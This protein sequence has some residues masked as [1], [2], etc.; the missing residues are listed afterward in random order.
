M[1]A[2]EIP[3]PAP[4]VV[5]RNDPVLIAGEDEGEVKINE[6]FI[7]SAMVAKLFLE[8]D[9]IIAISHFKGHMMTGFGGALKNIGM[10]CAS[11]QGKLQQHSDV[12]PRS[13]SKNCTGCAECLKDCPVEAITM[14]N[15][16]SVVDSSKCIGCA[17]CIAKCKFEAM[18]VE[19]ESGAGNIQ[20][21]M[22][23][24]A[25]AALLGKE[26]K[27]GFINFAIKI[28]KECDCL[29]KDDPRISPDIGI[30]VSNDPVSI[31]KASLDLV[32]RACGK[33][34]FKEA[35]PLRD[36]FRQLGHASD[37]GLGSLD[38]ELIEI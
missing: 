27:R 6:K 5:V 34:I 26:K 35:H 11:R 18:D 24:Y 25:K 14:V 17:A 37:I 29:A 30:L 19:W 16:K 9:A 15:K 21:K 20:E 3:L 1:T 8:V 22:V 2:S 13:S 4:V 32:I 33:D 7:R 28:T 38:Y 10:G 31:D 23:E 36:G 12:S